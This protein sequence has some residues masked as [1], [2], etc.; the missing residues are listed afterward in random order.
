M[1][2]A[3]SYNRKASP[4]TIVASYIAFLIKYF[5]CAIYISM[6]KVSYYK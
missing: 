3:I 4:V 6:K 5:Y 1:P 2:R